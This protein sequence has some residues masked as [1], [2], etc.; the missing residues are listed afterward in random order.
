MK[1]KKTKFISSFSVDSKVTHA[2]MLTLLLQFWTNY[3]KA[4]WQ[5]QGSI[6][7]V[8]SCC[9]QN[10]EKYWYLALCNTRMPIQLSNSMSTRMT[11]GRPLA[12]SQHKK[13]SNLALQKTMYDWVP[14]THSTTMQ[15]SW[16]PTI[17]GS[18]Q[19]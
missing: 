13:Y 14:Q 4:M 18:Q 15:M 16:I 3:G 17:W 2:V 10:H 8:T 11:D 1:K 19:K 6:H 7:G 5:E 12:L 9:Q